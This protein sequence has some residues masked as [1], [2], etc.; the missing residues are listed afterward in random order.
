M[1]GKI[2][3]VKI[4]PTPT[5]I[6]ALV[7][8]ANLIRAHKPLYNIALKDDRSFLGV[9]ITKEL[10]PRV[11]ATR[12]TKKL[13]DGDWYGP[14]TSATQLR[15]ALKIIRRLFPWC[16]NPPTTRAGGVTGQPVRQAKACFGRHLGL[17]LGAC[18]GE[19]GVQ[20]YARTISH[21]RLFLEGK[22]AR[23]ADSIARAMKSAAKNERFEQA[24]R[25]R[26]QL[27]ALEHIRESALVAMG[28]SPFVAAPSGERIEFFDVSNLGPTAI[29][30]AMAVVTKGKSNPSQYRRFK[31]RSL[32]SPNDGAS[33][34]EIVRRRFD[35]ADWPRPDLVVVDGGLGQVTAARQ[36]LFSRSL[37]IPVIGIAKG[38]T[39]KKNELLGDLS[40]ITQN[41][42]PLSW[43][44]LGRDEAHRF[45]INYSRLMARKQF[46]ADLK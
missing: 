2:K 9:F 44:M 5:N 22:K 6:E 27:Q 33:I 36:A 40:F 35:H 11:F 23:V 19:I 15:L 18:S 20:E 14:Y 24:A 30:G 26:R 16:S 46:T 17:C 29:V 32:T 7:L 38:P 25:L 1:V 21:L 41:K 37:A 39:R 12:A 3:S 10:Y 45:A 43:L 28:D 13:P 4:I 31:I 8:E 42:I 34:A